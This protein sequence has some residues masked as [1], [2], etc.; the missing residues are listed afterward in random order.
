MSHEILVLTESAGPAQIKELAER[1]GWSPAGETVRSHFVLASRRYIDQ[2]D[3]LIEYFEDHIGEVRFIQ[4]S[5]PSQ[6]PLADI[7]TDALPCHSEEQL[8]EDVTHAATP[9]AWIRGLSR[10]AVCHPVEVTA[11]YLELWTKAFQHPHVAVRR[12]AIRTAYS[13]RWPE[14]IPLVGERLELD[15]ELE[16][17]LRHLQEFLA[18]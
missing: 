9:L 3:T 6:S 1:R 7:L 18:R 8:L 14:L 17:P 13:C 15:H 5:G 2:D 16:G 12:A 11:P 4:I 10:L